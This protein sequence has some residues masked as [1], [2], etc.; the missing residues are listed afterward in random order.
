MA[1][2]PIRLAM[3]PIVKGLDL[4]PQTRCGHW[5]SALDIIAIK[6]RCCGTYYA[7]RA[8]HDA[9][10]DHPAEVW[11]AEAWDQPAILCG[12]CGVELSIDAYLAC[13]SRCPAC[14]APFNPG[15][16]TH[17]HLYFAAS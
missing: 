9:L 1:K 15:C 6:M 2:T 12:A 8:C 16:R 4:D 14:A 10:A 7:C 5:R 17:H 13:D 11:P 3:R